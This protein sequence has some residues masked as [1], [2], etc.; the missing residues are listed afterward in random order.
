MRHHT[1]R[2]DRAFSWNEAFLAD[3]DPRPRYPTQTQM[4][5]PAGTS[6]GFIIYQRSSRP[7]RKVSRYLSKY[8]QNFV[9]IRLPRSNFRTNRHLGC[10]NEAETCEEPIAGLPIEWQATCSNPL[11]RSLRRYRFC[12]H[13]ERPAHFSRWTRR[14]E[15]WILW[16]QL[17]PSHDIPS[18]RL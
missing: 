1:Q 15:P 12:N 13:R 2:S 14:R 9:R 4:R 3:P 10:E 11:S 17:A 8:V 5:C 6:T 16:Q 7:F 18:H